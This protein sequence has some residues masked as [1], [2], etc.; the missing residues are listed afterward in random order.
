M[1]LYLANHPSQELV[2]FVLAVL[3]YLLSVRDLMAL[4]LVAAQRPLG[5][6]FAP[7]ALA[8]IGLVAAAQRLALIALIVAAAPALVVPVA[9]SLAVLV[10]LLF[11]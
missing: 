9:P 7:A 8:Q 10:Y 1:A 3:V 11:G 4:V 6:S 5:R 2:L